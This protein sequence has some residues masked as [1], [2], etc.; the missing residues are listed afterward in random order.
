[1]GCHLNID[2]A[3]RVPKDMFKNGDLVYKPNILNFSNMIFKISQILKTL[4]LL[5]RMEYSEELEDKIID[6][7]SEL[8]YYRKMLNFM[9]KLNNENISSFLTLVLTYK[10]TNE[11]NIDIC[12]RIYYLVNTENITDHLEVLEKA[13]KLVLKF[14][15]EV[16][17]Y[18]I[19][20]SKISLEKTEFFL[21]VILSSERWGDQEKHYGKHPFFKFESNTIYSEG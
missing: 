16:V 20:Y 21:P 19:E 15:S 18:F 7:Q 14:S 10:C 5:K 13:K 17:D 4:P 3:I 1:M 8:I 6:L 9:K 2:S 11:Y 12:E